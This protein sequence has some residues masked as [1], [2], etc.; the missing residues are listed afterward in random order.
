MT[1]RTRALPVVALV[2]LALVLGGL[3]TAATAQTPP[4]I[5]PFIGSPGGREVVVPNG[6]YSGGAIS[7]PHDQWLVLRAQTPGQ[8][9]VDLR[10]TGLQLD[11]GT[12]KIVFVG[13]RFV[14]GTVRLSGVRDVHFWYCSFSFPAEEWARQYAAAG[15][16]A[17]ADR[18]VRNEFGTRMANPLPTA[19]RMRQGMRNTSL[20]NERVGF[21]GSDFSDIGDDGIFVTRAQQVNV[22]GVRIWNIDERRADPGRTL[23]SSQDWFHNDAIQTVGGVR[24]VVVADSWI[25]QK[26]QWGAEGRHIESS[27]FRNLWYAGSSTFGQINDIRNGGRILGNVQDNIRAFGNG[28]RNGLNFDFLR[29]DFVD[30][31]QR[32]IGDRH[33]YQAG[34]FEMTTT[35]VTTGPP[36]GVVV[37]DGRLVD[38]NQ[39]RDHQDNPANRWRAAQPYA[40]YA[41]FLRTVGLALPA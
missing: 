5:V 12:S 31:V 4:S 9:V 18:R 2:L 32:G 30:G 15:G 29:T 13:F 38:I 11:D 35:R 34:V 40:T 6:V 39:V 3:P 21:W 7:A 25:G 10:D 33:Y 23:G 19:V 17:P 20:E 14:N 37:R 41:T 28:Q 16:S 26:V 1:L 24:G 22:A 8:V 27:A 36:A